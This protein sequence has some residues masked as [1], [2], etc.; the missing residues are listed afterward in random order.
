M[1]R[2]SGSTSRETRRE[3]CRPCRSCPCLAG[4]AA[5]G[6]FVAACKRSCK[7]S[8]FGA[9]LGEPLAVRSFD[10]VEK[11]FDAGSKIVEREFAVLFA[12][13]IRHAEIVEV[14][15]L[16][17]PHSVICVRVRKS[18][19]QIE[20]WPLPHDFRQQPAVAQLQM[21]SAAD[22][23]AAPL[24]E[25]S[26]RPRAR[27]SAQL[28]LRQ[29]VRLRRVPCASSPSWQL[30]DQR[31][32]RLL[33]ARAEFFH[34]LLVAAPSTSSMIASSAPVSKSASGPSLR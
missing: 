15:S 12:L 25:V 14:G 20:T 3:S 27:A 5:R 32:E 18:G 23:S 29:F 30:A 33:L 24:S 17:H 26:A 31:V 16:R 22:V 11:G 9:D 13:E 4:P 8:S 21:S 2:P 19:P 28:L 1:R 10:P 6:V 7:T 34:R